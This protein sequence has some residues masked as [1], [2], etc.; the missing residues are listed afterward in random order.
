MNYTVESHDAFSMYNI[1]AEDSANALLSA[2]SAA[3]NAHESCVFNLK[4]CG[5]IDSSSAHAIM[6]FHQF[7]YEN[8]LSFAM[9]LAGEELSQVIKQADEDRILN[10][11]P[12][13]DEAID[14]ISMEGLER[15]LMSGDDF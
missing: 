10:L 14:L 7:Q 4:D 6:D 11:V 15:E 3:K 13:L 9:G 12:T 5:V 8:D 1:P 2:I